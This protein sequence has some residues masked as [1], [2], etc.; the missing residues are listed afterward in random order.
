MELHGVVL[1]FFAGEACV[2]SYFSFLFLA[3]LAL[4]FLFSSLS[5]NVILLIWFVYFLYFSLPRVFLSFPLFSFFIEYFIFHQSLHY[6]KH[7]INIF[8]TPFPPPLLLLVLCWWFK[9]SLFFCFTFLSL[10]L[11]LSSS[12]YLSRILSLIFTA[13]LFL[14]FPS[15]YFSVLIFFSTLYFI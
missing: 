5:F 9:C 7:F 15:I 3:L 12:F 1:Y 2:S 4:V 13:T 11:S 14:S 6:H 10:Y 8:P